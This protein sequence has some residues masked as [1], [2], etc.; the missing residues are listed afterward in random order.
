MDYLPDRA[1]ARA[2]ASGL[3]D[4]LAAF[5]DWMVGKQ[6]LAAR[7]ADWACKAKISI[8]AHSM[9]NFLLQ[10][11]MQTVWTRKNRPLLL[12]LINQLIMVAADVDND[13]FDSGEKV[14][15]TDGDAIANLTYR[16][17]SLYSGRDTVLG[18]SA[19]LK[20]FGKRRLG[21]SGFSDP[22]PRKLP[23]NVWQVDCSELFGKTTNPHSAYFDS[24]RVYQLMRDILMGLDRG[25]ID[26]DPKPTR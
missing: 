23:D 4:V 15:G 13:L 5:H 24:P 11:A 1:D 12:C 8:I 3:A 19:G 20:H 9:G 2:S 18:M 21:R 26:L 6:T 14:T 10:H 22:D 25:Q 7:N 16:I 17:T